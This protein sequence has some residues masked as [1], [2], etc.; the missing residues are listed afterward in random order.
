ML[1]LQLQCCGVKNYSDWTTTQWFNSS[2]NHSVPHSCC[3]Q[4]AKN[5]TGH[6]DR[7]QE[8]N[9]RVRMRDLFHNWDMFFFSQVEL[10]REAHQAEFRD[11]PIAV[12]I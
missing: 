10:W 3:Q 6:L 11:M 8:L 7:P 4:E 12:V 2:G 5:C 9:T 1:C